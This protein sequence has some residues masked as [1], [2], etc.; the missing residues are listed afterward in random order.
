[1]VEDSGKAVILHTLNLTR[2]VPKLVLAEAEAN[3]FMMVLQPINTPANLVE[4]AVLV[5]L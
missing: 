5:E 3:V 4:K 2:M 1:M